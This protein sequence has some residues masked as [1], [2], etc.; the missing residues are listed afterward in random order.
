V[1]VCDVAETCDGTLKTCPADAYLQ[2]PTACGVGYLCPGT[3]PSCP[4][5]C[6]GDASC[7]LGYYCGPPTCSAKKAD[8]VACASAHECASNLCTGFFT[9]ADHDGFGNP[10]APVTLCGTGPFVGYASTSTDCCDTDPN[11]HPGQMAWFPTPA[12]GCGNYDYNCFNGDERRWTA[13]GTCGAIPSC[14]GTGDWIGG[15]PA[16]G[17]PGSPPNDCVRDGDL[18]ALSGLL[19]VIQQCH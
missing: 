18:C 9:D 19:T 15:V 6:A 4:A 16:C 13:V 12:V 5:S 17:V 1:D 2:P 3:S 11:A 14:T 7:A 10:A 8:G